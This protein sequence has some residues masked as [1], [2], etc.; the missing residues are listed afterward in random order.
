MKFLLLS[1]LSLSLAKPFLKEFK[2][3]DPGISYELEVIMSQIRL[4][5]YPYDLALDFKKSL[6][7]A[8]PNFSY[9]KKSNMLF[10]VKTEIYAN[11]LKS[12]LVLKSNQIRLTDE[13]FKL[14]REKFQT[15]QNRLLPF[16]KWLIESI[17]S[18]L[19]QSKEFK[20]DKVK[21]KLSQIIF[22]FWK[23][24]INSFNQDVS[25]IALKIVLDIAKKAQY[26]KLHTRK[27]E[28][29]IGDQFF[30]TAPIERP[31]TPV[32]KDDQD[33]LF[34]PDEV[35]P[36]ATATELIDQILQKDEVKEWAPK[37]S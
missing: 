22:K 29:A 32:K 16:S 33:K 21:E 9:L 35:K 19:T 25:E 4:S 27:Q 30:M 31:T 14:I 11:L 6:E 23:Q 34:S 10:L 28:N 7:S 37:D 8:N 15:E 2:L 36:N 24:T 26:F 1:L 13:V 20:N 12:K 18:D 3:R 5:H 17:I